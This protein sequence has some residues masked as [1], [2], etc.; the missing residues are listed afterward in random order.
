VVAVPSKGRADLQSPAPEAA[1]THELYERHARA[2]YY[3]CLGRLRN[4]EEAE[5]AT[6]STF[7]N[8]FRGLQRGVAPE[9]EAAWLHKI[10]ENVCLTRVRSSARRRRVE[11]PGDLETVADFL[12][13]PEPDAEELRALPEALEAMPEQQRRALLLREWQGLSYREIAEELDLSQSAVETLLFRARRTLAAGLEEPPR[14]KRLS[15]LRAGGDAGWLTA[16]LK[17][18]VFGGGGKAALVGAV[19][20]SSAIGIA[21]GTRVAIEDALTPHM[22]VAPPARH[23]VAPAKPKATPTTPVTAPVVAAPVVAAPAL[24]TAQVVHRRATRPLV[25]HHAK[26]HDNGLHRGRSAVVKPAHGADPVAPQP[27]AP[28]PSTP[29]EPPVTRDP[30]PAAA[31]P[32]AP[33]PAADGETAAQGNG[34]SS[35]SD[36]NGSQNGKAGEDHSQGQGQGQAP[37]QGKR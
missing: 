7:L 15:R 23:H 21:P 17:M 28:T 14:K 30:A 6:Q 1:L 37:G 11:S 5:D 22:R 20:A 34:H 27:N 26:G 8:A 29:T 10:A 35:S 13:A 36:L 18:F 32:P 19:A 16:L 4:P 2:I 9:H 24:R 31:T 12:P 33:T 25:A 3:F